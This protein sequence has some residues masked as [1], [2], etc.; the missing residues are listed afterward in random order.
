MA[1]VRGS[2]GKEKA[3]PV[4]DEKA[5][6]LDAYVLFKTTHCTAKEAVA[7]GPAAAGA[8]GPE[9]AAAAGAGAGAGAAEAPAAPLLQAKQCKQRA[10]RI[11]MGTELHDAGELQAQAL[12]RQAA[13]REAH[14]AEM[15]AWKV[16]FAALAK[17][18]PKGY[19]KED[20]TALKQLAFGDCSPQ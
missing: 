16:E 5:A 17:K 14:Q 3:A 12:A 2:R 6:M 10:P 11:L 18:L 9:A 13:A 15:Q 20:E 7:G 4:L 1:S 19:T 8:P